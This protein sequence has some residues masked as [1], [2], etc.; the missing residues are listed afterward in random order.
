MKKKSIINTIT[1][2]ALPGLILSTAP[3]P[4]FSNDTG[5]KVVIGKTVKL[6][7]RILNEE[8][9]LFIYL[10]DGYSESKDRYPVLYICTTGEDQFRDTSGITRA[11]SEQSIIPKIMVVGLTD[12]DGGR[13]LTPTKT[14]SYGPTSGGADNFL[15]YIKNEVIPFVDKNY[16]TQPCRIIWG[17]S[18]VG[19]LCIY[20]FLSTPDTFNIF[21]VSSPWLIYDEEEMFLLKNTESFLKKRSSENNFLFL[22]VGNEPRLLPGIK[23]FIKILENK[24][25]VG[26]EWEFTTMQNEN[27]RSIISKGLTEGLRAVYSNWK[28][29]PGSCGKSSVKMP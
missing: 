7:S 4:G 5:D 9:R 22:T 23:A 2:F 25:P 17:H 24:K 16:R 11:L 1:M 19:T 27:H 20:A 28:N 12:I 13:D 26:V 14:D 3:Y 18:I 15:K 10:P 21:I 6:K 29:I 8:R